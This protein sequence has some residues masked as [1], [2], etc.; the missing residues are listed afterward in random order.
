MSRAQMSDFFSALSIYIP[1][2]ITSTQWLYIYWFPLLTWI[3]LNS[4]LAY[5]TTYSTSPFVCLTTIWNVT[6]LKPNTW[7]FLTN[8]HLP[9]FP[10]SV[11]RNS[12]LTVAQGENLP[13]T[14]F[15]TQ[16]GIFFP[17]LLF[18]YKLSITPPQGFSV[19]NFLCLKHSS[20]KLTIWRVSLYLLKFHFTKK[21]CVNQSYLNY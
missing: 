7:P 1:W 2:V 14:T 19:Y 20:L 21:V 13:L 4:R 11:N 6:C 3:S 18:I 17:S 10:I 9:V 8:P 5:S 16:W 12:N 15:L